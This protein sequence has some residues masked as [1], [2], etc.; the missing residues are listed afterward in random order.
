MLRGVT[1]FLQ[2][3]W[4]SLPFWWRG[5]PGDWCICLRQETVAAAGLAPQEDSLRPPPVTRT[6]SPDGPA[7]IPLCPGTSSRLRDC[8]C[9]ALHRKL[10][11]TGSSQGSG[12]TDYFV[13][14]LFP[15]SVINWI[16]YT[17]AFRIRTCSH[18]F[19]FFSIYSWD[20]LQAAMQMEKAVG[21]VSFGER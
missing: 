7:R 17:M 5:P 21:V 14:L 20:Q 19:V 11:A 9:S 13:R 1:V 16:N 3:Q 12:N 2:S 8:W 6:P 4:W 10:L 15:V 18:W